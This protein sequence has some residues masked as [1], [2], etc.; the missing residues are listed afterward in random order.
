MKVGGKKLDRP[1]SILCVLVIGSAKEG[2]V[3]EDSEELV[4]K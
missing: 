3:L 1:Q 4:A 2:F